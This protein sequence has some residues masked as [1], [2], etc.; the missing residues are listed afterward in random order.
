MSICSHSVG[1]TNVALKSTSCRVRIVT[2]IH[3]QLFPLAKTMPM[4]NCVRVPAAANGGQAHPPTPF[5]NST[6]RS[7]AST[8][9]CMD[10]LDE[11]MRNVAGFVGAV[12]LMAI[13]L[14]Q[15]GFDSNIY[16]GG[17]GVFEISIL[18]ALLLQRGGMKGR[19]IF[20]ASYSHHQ[21]FRATIYFLATRDLCRSPLFLDTDQ[22]LDVGVYGNFMPV[23]FDGA[24][25]F[26]VLFKMTAWSYAKVTGALH[27]YLTGRL[28]VF[29][30]AARSI[31]DF[32]M[33]GRSFAR[34][35]AV[36]FHC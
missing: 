11:T 18:V 7:E 23:F 31:L 25:G 27:D 22:T 15:R 30:A 10:L 4:K 21:L 33:S 8:V 26:N 2:A 36:L 16:A 19:P 34:S 1:D 17:F 29:S 24:F 14:R 28:T 12:R 35:L 20:P 13:W 6:L 5:Y 32:S 9:V 3:P